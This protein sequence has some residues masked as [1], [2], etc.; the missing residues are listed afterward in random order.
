MTRFTP[1]K[2]GVDV[3]HQVVV[4][5]PSDQR[6]APAAT[7]IAADLEQ[8][9]CRQVRII[10]ASDR[11][12]EIGTA[13]PIVLGNSANNDLIR[14]LYYTA[15]DVTDRAWPGPGGWAIRSVANA[16]ADGADAILLSVSDSDDAAQ[17][18]AA[19]G[20]FLDRHGLHLPWLHQVELGRWGQLYLDQIN[21]LL[22]TPEAS[23]DVVG[24]GSGDWDYM[25][26]IG[27]VGVL[28]VKT[29]DE[30]LILRFTTELLRFLRVRF[31]ERKLE[32]P[33]QI[34]GF[35]RNLLRP[36]AMLEHHP[37]LS[38]SL[39]LEVLQALLSVYRST[40]GAANI[41]LL[42]DSQHARVRQNH[43]TR[44]ALD[45]Y[46]GGL[47][48]W[49]QHGLEEGRQW[50]QLAA[51]FFEPQMASSK[52]VCDSWGHQWVASLYNTA[53]YALLAERF[54]YFTSSH[55]I[56]AA[57]RALI[58]HTNLESGPL[59]Y[60][61]LAAAVTGHD[62]YLS[63]CHRQ[64]ASLPW[65]CPVDE[66]SVDDG[67]A[68][69]EDRLVQRALVQLGADEFGRAWIS[70]SPGR[71]PG[72][73]T[74]VSVAPVARLFYDSI[75]SYEAFAPAGVYRR[76]VPFESTF[77]KVSYRSGWGEQDTY[78]LLDGISGGSHSYQ[79]ANCIVRFTSRGK[80]WLGGP[81]YGTWTT[82][83]VREQ[84][85]VSVCCDGEGA[86]CEAR[87]AHLHQAD[88]VAGVGLI[89]TSLDLPGVA[90]W[91][92]QIVTHPRGWILVCDEIVASKEGEFSL[93]AQW[94]LLGDV[95]EFVDEV[96]GC[97][98]KSVQDAA[99]LTLRQVGSDSGWLTPIYASGQR[100][101][102]RWNLRRSEQLTAGE[103]ILMVTLLSVSV[104]SE[105]EAPELSMRGQT[106]SVEVPGHP[107]VTVQFDGDA[108]EA[109]VSERSIRLAAAGR[110]QTAERRIDRRE[111]GLPD[112]AW[113]RSLDSP[114]SAIET[115]AGFCLVGTR[116]GEVLRLSPEGDIEDQ[117]RVG[118][119]ICAIVAVEDGGMLTGCVDGTLHRYDSQGGQLWSHTVK[120]QPMNWDNWTRGN[121]AVLCLAVGDFDGEKRI[122]A[123]CAD[124]HLYGFGMD[125]EPLWRSPCQWGPAAHVAIATI[126]AERKSRILM[127]M[128]RPAIHAWCRIY[129]ANG[130]YVR[131]LQRP[132]V[133]SWSIPSWM[134]GLEVADVD[135]DGRPE[136][137]VGMDTNHR[138]LV[139]YRTD[140]EILWDADV[141][142]SVACVVSAHGRLY[143]G[144]EG[145]WVHNFDSSGQRLWSR[146]VQRPVRGLAPLSPDRTIVALDDGS[147]CTIGQ[148]T[149]SAAGATISSTKST[150][151]WPGRGLLVGADGVDHIALFR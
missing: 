110:W 33:I 61:L 47:Y 149:S 52:P 132:D 67:E 116:A 127:G 35:L 16:T 37:L 121:C 9:G 123:G 45:V 144:T 146:Y 107:A 23:L 18:A 142:S 143:T 44:T 140:G 95:A 36:F 114:V 42:N 43:G 20:Q 17:A 106:L 15:R 46:D 1:K 133:V 119:E 96:E 12:S 77:D 109:K 24:G 100:V 64:D 108:D 8:A 4:L 7:R 83:T 120:W 10:A 26:A 60:L 21:D 81:Q 72:R 78:L 128:A 111:D 34:H 103:S 3:H 98:V 126:G 134:T 56:D 63:L 92:R 141:G 11:E 74:G 62:E 55:F 91:Y 82:G 57:D 102:T 84:N 85:G 148:A 150:A 70:G 117:V 115:G 68:G 97:G 88:T 49:Q 130:D 51:R 41:A 58:A 48:F 112:P 135:G 27:R 14:T 89:R 151:Y 124:R 39:R 122:I 59:F 147:I 118:E 93:Q 139:V 136:V 99:C 28:A 138:Q 129:K 73:L 31:S 79:D 13:T 71:C 104:A 5:V 69:V 22:P 38:D 86:G 137:I 32:D 30:K 53:E 75:E 87:Y 29:G 131:A 54:D 76:D 113:C 105:E 2:R 145:G 40:E 66:T 65:I 25:M 101:S 125:G 94:N 80:S 50:M 19:F 90:R 6:Y